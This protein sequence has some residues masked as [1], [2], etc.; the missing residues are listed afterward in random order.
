MYLKKDDTV[1]RRRHR[2]DF[3][4]SVEKIHHGFATIQHTILPITTIEPVRALRLVHEK[5]EGGK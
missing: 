3:L 5:R 4:F 2:R 1:K